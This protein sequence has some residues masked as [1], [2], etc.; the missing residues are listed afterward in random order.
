VFFIIRTGTQNNKLSWQESFLLLEV[1]KRKE[2]LNMSDRVCKAPKS[3]T[4]IIKGRLPKQGSSPKSGGS[5]LEDPKL[6][7]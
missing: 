7:G 3:G 1:F 6:G 5:K 2:G 4:D